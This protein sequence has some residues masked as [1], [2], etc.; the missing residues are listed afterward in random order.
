MVRRRLH[1]KMRFTA[2]QPPLLAMGNF[3]HYRYSEAFL[4]DLKSEYR[5]KTLSPSA[6]EMIG[7]IKKGI[8]LGVHVRRG[9][10]V[11]NPIYHSIGAQEPEYYLQGLDLT[12]QHAGRNA[13]IYV[14]S[15]DIDWVRDALDLR[16]DVVYVSDPSNALTSHDEFEM[17]KHCQHL[18]LSNSSFSWWAARLRECMDGHVVVPRIWIREP[19]VMSAEFCPPSWLAV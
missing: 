2:L 11:D 18:V 6:V 17:M 10:Y 8:S 15:N 19:Q 4:K 12:L 3:Q 13:T 7:R 9:D 5:P 16:G 14:F 1:T